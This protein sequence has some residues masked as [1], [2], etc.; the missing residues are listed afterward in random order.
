MSPLRPPHPLRFGEH[1]FDPALNE[2][3]GPQGSQRLPLKQAD[4]LLRLMREPGQPVRRETLLDEVWERRFVNEE[5]LS[6][7]IADLRA[8]L[9]DDAKAPRYIETL[10]KVGYRFLAEVREEAA[11][12][13]AGSAPRSP[14]RRWPL[15]LAAATGLLAIAVLVHGWYL[16]FSPAS[17]THVLTPARLLEARP[18]TAD[19]GRELFP[20]F[21]PDARWVA[22]TRFV[23]G[24]EP[25]HL[26]LRTVDGTEDRA[27]VQDEFEN[28]C[29][30]IS[31]DEHSGQAW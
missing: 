5:V 26:R 23:P 6:R 24:G 15:V 13:P 1:R 12:S 25:A 16:R 22:Y 28:Y 30:A 4:L 27:L 9:G 19:P 20:R 2:L 3:T 10:P 17:R 29:G 18:F 31:P 21:T 8:A 7:A 11:L 14:R